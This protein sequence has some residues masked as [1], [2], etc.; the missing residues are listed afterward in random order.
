MLAVQDL[1][2]GD[3]DADRLVAAVAQRVLRAHVRQV[4]LPVDRREAGFLV[5]AGDLRDDRLELLARLE[6][7]H[8]AARERVLR[9]VA[10][11]RPDARRRLVGVGLDQLRVELA[12]RA[13][14]RLVR[15]PERADPDFGV[16]AV[17]RRHVGAR[18]FLGRR[19]VAAGLEDVDVHGELVER[20]A[21]VGAEVAEALEQ[22]VAHRVEVDLVRLGGEVVL[23]LRI[24]LGVGVDL[25][26]ALAEPADGLREVL[27]HR[28]AG[29]IE[30]LEVEHERLDA[31]VVARLVDDVHEVAHARLGVE[32]AAR[33][34]QRALERVAGMFLDQV[35]LGR[36]HERRAVRDVGQL[37]LARPRGAAR[38]A[39]AG[40]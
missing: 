30:A 33:P 10:A 32:L 39:R 28:Q 19:L 17:L 20:A 25:L 24:G 21:E 34:R 6:A 27:Q 8:Q 38:T 31:V 23:A 2:R 37:G 13:D 5:L 14:V 4:A 12:R 3:D 1:A 36:Q 15:V 16:L 26:A 11:G 9:E 18:P 7:V 22:D 35:S 40:G 29:A